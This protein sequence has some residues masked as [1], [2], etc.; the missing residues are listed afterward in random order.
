MR[1]RVYRVM[2][3]WRIVALAGLIG[4]FVAA[5]SEAESWEEI[6]IRSGESVWASSE[7]EETVWGRRIRYR[8]ENVFDGELGTCWVE[9][10]EGAGVGES[11]TFVVDR[12]VSELGIVNGFARNGVLFRWNNRVRRLRVE[13]VAAFTAPGL[14]TETDYTLYLGRVMRAAEPLELE[15]TAVLQRFAF[16]W[17]ADEQ[18]RF[19][20]ESLELFLDGH[21]SFARKIREAF[22]YGP[23]P[24]RGEGRAAPGDEASR[25]AFL[26]DAGAAFSMLCVRLVIDGVYPGDRFDDTC[27]TE[28]EVAFE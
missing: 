28:I 19:F 15:D 6:S 22:G 24:A 13:L 3:R 23:D 16:P 26:S 2:V 17:T 18:E 12:P 21:P 5:A 7:L 14:V 1:I 27:I 11:L 20:M 8:A 9:D 10:A 4:A 25:E